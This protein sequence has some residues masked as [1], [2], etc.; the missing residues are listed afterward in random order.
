MCHV[1]GQETCAVMCRNQKLHHIC[2]LSSRQ[3]LEKKV[4][5]CETFTVNCICA[6]A[7]MDGG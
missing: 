4:Q 7:L 3:C 2:H 5:H 1:S 6:E